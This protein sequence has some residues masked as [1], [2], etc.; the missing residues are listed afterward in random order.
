MTKLIIAAINLES[1][2]TISGRVVGGLI[3]LA[4]SAA[5][6][7]WL[8]GIRYIPH[9]KVGIV[10]KLWSPKGS[11]TEGGMVALEGEAG[12]QTTILRGG[13]HPWYFPWQYRIHKEPLVT[14]AEGKI[15]YV[16]ARDGAPLPPTQT[17]G[18]IVESNHFQDA[19]SFLR[20]GGQRGRQRAILR[21]GVFAINQALFVVITDDGY[22]SG[23]VKDKAAAQI[24]E[25]QNQL[26]AVGGFDPV[27]IGRGNVTQA[28]PPHGH[29]E[30]SPRLGAA[31]ADTTLLPSDTL[32]IVTVHDGAPIGSGEIIAPE[33]KPADGKQDHDYFQNPEAFL[34]LGGRRGK[35]LQVLTDGTFFINRWFAT[36]EIRPKLLIPIG[37][38]G[39]VVSYYGSKGEDVTGVT[40]RY[41]EQVEPGLRGVWKQA[42]PPGKFALNPYA[43]KVELVPTVN[44]VLRWITGVVESHQ[45]DKDLLSI[46]LITADGYEPVLPLSLVL[47]IDY[48]KAPRVVQRFGDVKRLIT[49]TLDP[50][51]TS[52]FRD[53]AQSSHMLDLLTKREEI[54][55]RATEQLGHRFQ[56]YDINCVAVLI[57]RPESKATPAGQE[58]PIER[59]FDQLR[60]RR[61]AAEQKETFGR[62][63]EA[64]VRLKELNHAR[65]AAEKQTELTQT[66]I[67]V[68]VAA[69]KGE[70]QLAE[71]QRLA[72]RDIARAEGESRAKELLG[73]GEGARIAQIGLSEA[74]VFLQKI[75]AYGDPRLFALSLVAD[76]FAK[77]AQ[78]LVPERLLLMG[79]AKDGE[80]KADF[81]SVS[82]LGQLLTLLLAE[83]A[84]LGV[85]EKGP[86]LGEL[87]KFTAQLT[88]K[89]SDE[90][91]KALTGGA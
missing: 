77:S 61:L 87:E 15:G 19:V 66:R 27:V 33:V 57:G 82:S 50:I 13:L 14:V 21:E 7:K 70:A 67:D 42:L 5:A 79:A 64:A 26:S 17:L 89:M 88:K 3:V 76:Q 73:K 44:F 40:F 22:Y 35:Q 29:G 49:Q 72:K 74:A 53:V 2:L 24:V 90:K 85:T 16:Y 51:L 34:D 60:I 83:K 56:D 4:L 36:V 52:Y 81:T 71:A 28:P 45:Y 38:V 46:E 80:G 41:G 86:D 91:D 37:Y 48:E 25:W 58:D 10:E 6:L 31:D 55:K 32:G 18:R 39:V 12:F 9:A 68:E 11:L 75:R 65:A 84:G 23:P 63:E 54:Q 8:L 69:N 43:L 30:T 20:K 62:Q 59:L 1:F 47:H 78:P